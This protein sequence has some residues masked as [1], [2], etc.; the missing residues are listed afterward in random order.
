MEKRENNEFRNLKYVFF[1]SVIFPFI[2]LIIALYLKKNGFKHFVS[3]YEVGIARIVQYILFFLGLFIFFFCEG[4]SD[5]IV[6]K[7][8]IKE[9]EQKNISSYYAYTIIMLWTLNLIT[10]VG[11]LGFLICGNITWLSV[12][13]IL[14][15]S[16]VYKYFPSKKHLENLISKLEKKQ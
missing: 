2:L 1:E 13:L 12:F 16:M 10:I 7:I 5:F 3:D 14:N 9:N 4:I 11:F 15:I 6:K 8:F